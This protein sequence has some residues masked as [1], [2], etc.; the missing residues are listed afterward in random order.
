MTYTMWL[1]LVILVVVLVLLVRRKS[2]RIT[3]TEGR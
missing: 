3:D 2:S 1:A